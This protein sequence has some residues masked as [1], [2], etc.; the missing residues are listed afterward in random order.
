M[1]TKTPE[2]KTAELKP[3]E[4]KAEKP[5]GKKLRKI[6][7]IVIV[8]LL[9]IGGSLGYYFLIYTNTFIETDNAKVT[10]K[11]YTLYPSAGGTLLQWEVSEGSYVNKDQVLGRT[12]T[13]PYISSPIKGT[14]VQN[15]VKENQTVGV[16]T[17]LAV[18]ADT[19]NL[20]IGVNIKET[21]I[22]KLSIGQKA[23]VKIDAY[24][25]VKFE[26]TVTDI[27]STT[28]TYFSNMTSFTTSGT[29]TKVTQYI[30]VK[31]EIKNPKNYLL[32][33]GMNSTVRLFVK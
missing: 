25:G 3:A 23:E 31:V 29:Y 22:S 14:V 17:L 9:I 33:F 10:A 19:D 28:Q 30:P 12:Q 21:E 26:G 4:T 18:V 1:E 16:S 6:L 15:N 24:P 8:L 11:M 5:K 32:I 7:P 2:T 20:Y 27:G 13:L